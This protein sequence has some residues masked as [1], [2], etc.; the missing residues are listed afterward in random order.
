MTVQGTE[1]T[2][3]EIDVTPPGRGRFDLATRLTFVAGFTFAGVVTAV[4]VALWEL[5]LGPNPTFDLVD[6]LIDHSPGAVATWAIENLG[7]AGK[8]LIT[9][10]GIVLWMVAGGVIAAGVRVVFP[11]ESSRAR[12]VTYSAVAYL[13]MTL[14]VMFKTVLASAA[15]ALTTTTAQ[16][17]AM[18]AAMATGIRMRTLVRMASATAAWGYGKKLRRGV[19]C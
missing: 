9:A 3:P 16:A 1:T 18:P 15:T 4:Y 14:L 19:Q 2:P 7:P 12:L 13:G 17:M 8:M 6:L 5:Q 11:E 10:S